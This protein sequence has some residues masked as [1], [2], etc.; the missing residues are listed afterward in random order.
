MHPFPHRYHVTASGS[1]AGTVRVSSESL[2]GLETI[3]YLDPRGLRNYAREDLHSH[4]E[5]SRAGRDAGPEARA[6]LE[7]RIAAQGG[8]DTCVMLY[9]SG[10]TGRP[11]GVV[12]SNRNIIETAR[13]SA[14]FDGL[15]EKDSVL[16]YLP[17]AWVGDFIFSMG[18]AWWCGFCV[19]CPES[20][21][22]MQHDLRDLVGR[23]QRRHTLPSREFA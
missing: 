19:A 1:A 5:V 22:T 18:Q 14:G 11:K 10:T 20:P 8:E 9:T 3:V 21:S 17:M 2:P 16:A 6:A 12:L 7:A 15:T 23:P 4:A 13:A